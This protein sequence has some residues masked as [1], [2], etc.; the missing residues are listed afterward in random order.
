MR[1]D[2]VKVVIG[3]LLHDIGKVV[4]RQGAD[5]RKH[6]QSGAEYLKNQANIEDPEILDCVRYH[7][8][9]GLQHTTLREDSFA[10]LVY[11]ADNIASAVDRREKQQPDTGF[12]IHTRMQPIFNILNGN[13]KEMYYSAA[14]LNPE[15]DIN[16]PTEAAGSFDANQYHTILQ[17]IT[18]NLKG[19]DWNQE[20]IHSLLEVL[21]ANLS[22]VPSSTSKK[23]LADI[24]LYDH[25][26][27]TAAVASSI[28]AYLEEQ[29]ITNYRK[30]LYQGATEF[31]GKKAFLLASMDV[32]GIQSFIYT[33]A[34]KNALKTLRSRSFYLEIMMEH[35]IDLLLQ[36]LHL[37]RANLI[38]SGGGHCY[39]LLPNT[40]RAKLIF[41]GFMEKINQWFREQFQISLYIAGGY[42]ECSCH[43]LH[44]IPQGSYQELFKKMSRMISDKKRNRYTAK[45]ILQLN[46]RKL[47]NYER[48]CRVCKRIGQV[49]EEGVCSFCQA[50]ENFSR[51][52]L[53]AKIFTVTLSQ[54]GEGLP[55]PGGYRL[56]TD[57]E[58]TLRRRI[59]QD[60]YFVRAYGKNKMYIGRH[61]AT[62]LWV[63]DYVSGSSFE[64]FAKRQEGIERI[65]ILRAD[66][67]NLG[68]AIVS[69]FENEDNQNRYVTLSRTATLSRQ[70][71][72][73]FKLYINQI[74]ENP[75][76]SLSGKPK[77]KRK[78][79][80]VYSGGDDLFIVG[81]WDDVIELAVDV[82]RS[83]ERYT[84]NT[85]TISAGI[86]IY[87]HNYP[88]SVIA[89]EVAGLEDKSKKKEGKNAITLLEDG[90]EHK[91]PVSGHEESISD[92]T[93]SWMELENQVIEEKLVVIRD[94][95]RHCDDRGMVFLYKLLELIRVQ[96]EKINFARFVYLIARMEPDKEA[97]LEQKNLYQ[98]FAQ[99]MY[100]WVSETDKKKKEKNCRQLK[101]AL[102][103]YAYLTRKREEEQ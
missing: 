14:M 22:F 38:Y 64:E 88:I 37:S 13:H 24:S 26:K 79:A 47:Q 29:Q 1:D 65:G 34:T 81:A 2:E 43:E 31:Y 55:L 93:Y 83:F 62:K 39:L 61:I 86:G 72:L 11:L 42:V 45:E 97:P 6:S 85:L 74:L 17:N 59:Q 46:H 25:L 58:D 78:A 80:I 57:T 5:R 101:T 68:K 63:G 35:I 19:N 53:Q 56:I 76:Y 54:K 51:K 92:G 48:E 84:E 71:S 50:I 52:I 87:H 36:E 18:D 66:V 91:E 69:G 3:A 16:Y 28:Y 70:L 89:E 75:Q 20:Y 98:K 49:S 99:S 95:F 102:T 73:F 10:Y 100:Q 77:E 94:F 40:K 44:N 32:S 8:A 15:G 9:D 4:Y 21:E 30:E 27:L 67:D 33:I 103:L 7:H 23:E 12:E 82:R 96:N 41:Q 90:C 60:D